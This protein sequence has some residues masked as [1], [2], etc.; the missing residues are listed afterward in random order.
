MVEKIL[1]YL[2]PLLRLFLFVIFIFLCLLPFGLITQF[3]FIPFPKEGL[4]S[5]LLSEGMMLLAILGALLMMFKVYPTLDFQRVFFSRKNTINGFLKGS[6]VGLLLMGLCAGVL[7]LSGH[8]VFTLDQLNWPLLMGY[9]VFFI[10]VAVF[11][12]V[13]FRTLPLFLFA[14]RYP[15]SLAIA[16]NGLLF[17]LLHFANPGFTWLAM[18][19]I[20]LAGV[21]FAIYTLQKRNISW[22]IGIHFTWNFA[23]GIILGYKV[24]GTTTPSLL[25]AKPMGNT[26]LSGG[27]FGIEGS[28]VCTL[29]LSI[30]I[31]YLMVRYPIA[32]VEEAV[33]ETITEEEETDTI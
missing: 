8:V 32:P 5:D 26:Y 4:F 1:Y 29:I 33:W 25:V 10:L 16:I 15:I 12:E 30:L 22:A 7:Y 27:L 23:Q 2:N 31:I 9:L 28:V 3:G 24:S 14:E 18:L 21:L 11:E 13:L 6:L 19:N 20:S 17:G